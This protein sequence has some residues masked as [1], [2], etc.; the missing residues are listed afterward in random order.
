MSIN[1]RDFILSQKYGFM[2]KKSKTWG[3]PWQEQFFVLTNIGLAYMINPSDKH[4]KL[5]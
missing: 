1:D 5:F 2:M 3:R 4:I